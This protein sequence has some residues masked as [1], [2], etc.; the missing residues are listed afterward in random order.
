MEGV[1]VTK[2]P[3]SQ[4]RCEVTVPAEE[5]SRAMQRAARR[6][7]ETL[8]VKGF[9]KGK[10]PD[11]VVR[12]EVGD[13]RLLQEA[14]FLVMEET[15]AR[16]TKEF[17]L[18]VAGQPKV[19]IMKIAPGNPLVFVIT[20]AVWPE[21][22]LADYRSVARALLKERTPVEVKEDEVHR[23]LEWLRQSRRKETLVQRPAQKGDAVE[24]NFESRV[25]GVRIE[26]GESRN[27]P[28][29][30]GLS[31]FASGFDEQVEG[32][33]QAEE[34]E[35]SLDIPTDHG[36]KEMRGKR[37]DFKVKLLAV[38]EAAV[39]ALN[40]AFA[41]S[42]GTFESA[43]ALKENVREGLHREKEMQEREAFRKKLAEA[44]AR[45]SRAEIADILVAQE[46]DKMLTDLESGL[47][48]H[49]LELESY[50]ST[51][52]KSVD[53]VRKD[54]RAQGEMRVKIA[55]VLAE[56]AKKEQV[57]VSDEELT[58]R[59]EEVLRKQTPEERRAADLALLSQYLS[60]II[61]NEK[62]FALLEELR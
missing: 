34:K 41:Q 9:R 7:G 51:M 26:G 45:E 15:Y 53:D 40:D 47:S 50:L 61:R 28:F 4:V 49:G 25:H 60:G 8:E 57:S 16:I 44:I 52:K 1:K 43:A 55:L 14:S 24:V 32:M 46:A 30:L 33:R 48:E 42:L 38:R 29:V 62:V 31:K 54:F 6:L 13:A 23:A 18:K 17:E 39:P 35:F 20:A 21:V 11:E 27:H 19:E 2:L 56:I 59:I 58:E 22:A 10:A 5:V 12:R 3:K 37:V 36:R